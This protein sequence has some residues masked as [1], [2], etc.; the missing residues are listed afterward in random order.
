VEDR[1]ERG[2]DKE[3]DPASSLLAEE[4]DGGGVWRRC[5]WCEY[6]LLVC[7]FIY[8]GGWDGGEGVG[9]MTRA[10]RCNRGCIRQSLVV[11]MV[12]PLLMMGGICNYLSEH[13]DLQQ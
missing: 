1:K 5:I 13:Q 6:L 8:L 4:G 12:A 10:N 7:L 3:E 11:G 9:D 2:R